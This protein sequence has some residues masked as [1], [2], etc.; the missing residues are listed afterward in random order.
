MKKLP[1][2]VIKE[3]DLLDYD[4]EEQIEFTYRYI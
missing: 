4:K 1:G 2:R 3:D